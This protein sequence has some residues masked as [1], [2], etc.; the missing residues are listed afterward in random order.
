MQYA[1]ELTDL[2]KQYPKFQLEHVS[3]RLPMGYVMGFIGENGAGKTTVMKSML[4]LIHP[5]SG[6]ILLLGQDA[7]KENAD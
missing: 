6:Q 7:S 5:D 4:H 3:F 1:I 2:G